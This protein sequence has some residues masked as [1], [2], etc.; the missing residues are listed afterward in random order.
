VIAKTL[1][2]MRL[3]HRGIGQLTLLAR[4]LNDAPRH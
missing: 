2:D 4:V 1:D 3:L